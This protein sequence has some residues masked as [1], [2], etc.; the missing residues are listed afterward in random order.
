[1]EL[2]TAVEKG[3][4]TSPK[5]AV[6]NLAGALGTTG[7]S[8]SGRGVVAHQG[9]RIAGALPLLFFGVNLQN[10]FKEVFV[11]LFTVH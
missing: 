6:L 1:M 8:C 9:P 5:N 10:R 11:Y 7:L 2:P 4:K 3:K